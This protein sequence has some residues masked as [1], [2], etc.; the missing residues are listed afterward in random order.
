MW[1]CITSCSHVMICDLALFHINKWPYTTSHSHVM[2]CNLAFHI[3]VMFSD[4]PPFH[5]TM[6]PYTTSYCH[7]IICDLVL[8]TDV[9]ICDLA[10]HHTIMVFVTLQ[11]FTPTCY[12]WPCNIYYITNHCT[13]VQETFT[14]TDEQSPQWKVPLLYKFMGIQ[15]LHWKWWS[16][17]KNDILQNY[18]D[19]CLNNTRYQNCLPCKLSDHIWRI[20]IKPF[21]LHKR[22]GTIL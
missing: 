6:W 9:M 17:W 16:G 2:I 3:K 1:P 7:V 21:A 5:T 22:S 10:T 18:A 12:L 11:H 15:S 8:H 4:L 20:Y 13:S 14:N 19:G